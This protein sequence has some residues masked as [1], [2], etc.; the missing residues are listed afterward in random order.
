MGT[1]AG[2]AALI[3]V[4]LTLGPAQDS[5]ILLKP[6]PLVQRGFTSYHAEH[7]KR[8]LPKSGEIVSESTF[9]YKDHRSL[10]IESISGMA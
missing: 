9:Y 2:I 5:K 6:T 4:L 10:V 7:T 8:R 3:G 1:E